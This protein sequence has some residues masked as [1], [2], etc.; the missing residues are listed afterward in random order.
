M[1]VQA[2]RRHEEP[3]YDP[4]AQAPPSPVPDRPPWNT[5]TSLPV[6]ATSIDCESQCSVS[7]I[8]MSSAIGRS[9]PPQPK[10]YPSLESVHLAAAVDATNI[11]YTNPSSLLL[12]SDSSPK[13]VRDFGHL[14]VTTSKPRYP[15]VETI[16]RL[17]SL[18]DDEALNHD[19]VQNGDFNT[20]KNIVETKNADIDTQDKVSDMISD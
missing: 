19:A 6:R 3:E 4:S 2:K 14:E 5:R 7:T 15:S 10:Y 9:L 13:A 20:V 8:S 16:A 11:L 18:E 12:P 17:T 1:M